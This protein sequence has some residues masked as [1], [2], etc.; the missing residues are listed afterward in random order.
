MDGWGATGCDSVFYGEFACMR[1]IT[2]FPLIPFKSDKLVSVIYV[3]LMS[4]LIFNQLNNL[5]VF[6][7]IGFSGSGF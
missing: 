1:L 2:L 4:K 3:I 7:A 6:R 5:L